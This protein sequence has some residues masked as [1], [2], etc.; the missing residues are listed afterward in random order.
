MKFQQIKQEEA[1]FAVLQMR[2][3]LISVSRIQSLTLIGQ[4]R[5]VRGA[6]AGLLKSSSHGSHYLLGSSQSVTPTPGWV[7]LLSLRLLQ[8]RPLIKPAKTATDA[9]N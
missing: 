8:L 2:S 7:R 6:S 5:L 9:R 3:D 1:K 4:Q